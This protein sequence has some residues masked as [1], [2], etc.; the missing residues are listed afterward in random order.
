MKKLIF[1]SIGIVLVALVG[2]N[3][4]SAKIGVVDVLK[5]AKE[6]NEG[7]K[8]YTELDALVKSKQEE[9]KQKTD[10][11]KNLE[12]K[13]GKAPDESKQPIEEELKKASDEYHKLAM[14]SE[15]EVK[16]RNN[17]LHTK[18]MEDLKKVINDIGSDEKF[19]LI[20]IAEN[21]PYFQKTIDISD[22]VLKRYNESTKGQ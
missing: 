6:S 5:I 7:R 12:D 22:K 21:T 2:C 20:L 10:S 15:A 4:Q 14:S 19:T 18:I 3:N 13:L 17:E 8:A 1:L 16:N 11:V 9:L